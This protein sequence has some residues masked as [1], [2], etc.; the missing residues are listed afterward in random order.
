MGGKQELLLFQKCHFGLFYYQ[1]HS[2]ANCFAN[3]SLH[4]FYFLTNCNG[5]FK[6]QSSR[7]FYFHSRTIQSLHGLPATRPEM[8]V[9]NCSFLFTLG[10]TPPFI[11]FI[12]PQKASTMTQHSLN[13][14][15]NGILVVCVRKPQVHV[16]GTGLGLDQQVLW[17]EW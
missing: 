15:N 10:Q 17:M 12:S 4:V 7:S 6:R 11:H 1:N 8:C 14:K 2:A 3:S 16:W 5:N 9:Q 13:S